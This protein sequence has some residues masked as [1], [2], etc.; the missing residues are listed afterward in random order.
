MRQMQRK[1]LTIF[2]LIFAFVGIADSAYLADASLTDTTL[3]CSING[4]EGCNVVAQSE[5][6]HLF[7][8]PLGVYGVVFYVL[9]FLTGAILLIKRWRAAY[10]SLLTLGWFGLLAS[11]AFELIQIFLIKAICVYCL[12]SAVLSIAIW[13]LGIWFWKKYRPL[14][15][16]QIPSMEAPPPA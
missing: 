1:V 11:A 8:I 12:G 13:L 15:V 6:A 10:V 4:L 16:V 3:A 14:N 9:V 7:G 2:L 5:Y